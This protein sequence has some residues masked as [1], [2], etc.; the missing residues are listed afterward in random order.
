MGRSAIYSA[1]LHLAIVL[2]AVFGLPWLFDTNEVIEVTPVSIVSA[3]QLNDLMREAKE[4]PKPPEVK[5]P[6]PPKPEEVKIPEPPA[7]APEPEPE[8]IPE[9]EVA[10][11]IPVPEP[12]IAEPEPLPEPEPEPLPVEQPQKVAV[13]KPTPPQKPIPPKKDKKKPEETPK[14]EGADSM[15]ALLNK[16][17]KEQSATPPQPVQEADVDPEEYTGPPLSEGEKDLIRQQITDSWLVDIGMQGIEDMSVEIRVRMNP[18]GSVQSAVADGSGNNGHPNW[19]IL[20]ESAVRAV[21]KSSPIRMPPDKPYEAW[22][23]M[24]LHFDVREML[25]L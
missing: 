15:S 12:V 14:E 7:P 17:N 9:P 4:R 10:E 22:A 1:G 6:E 3:D 23:T 19:P 16:L 18:D 20:A 21:Y 8:P 2:V 13:A 24:T 11:E 5:P 25:G